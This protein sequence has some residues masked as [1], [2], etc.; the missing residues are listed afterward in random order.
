[1]LQNFLFPVSPGTSVNK[2]KSQAK[3]IRS[4]E[5]EKVYILMVVAGKS[6][7]HLEWL[8]KIEQEMKELGLPVE[9]MIRYGHVPS[10]IVNAARSTRSIICFLKK[11]KNP[12]KKALA[13]S[14]VSDVVRM[15]DEPVLIYKKTFTLR[16]E[17][18][19][20]SIMYA[21]NFKRSTSTCVKYIQHKAFKARRLILLHVGRRAPDPEAEKKR[22]EKIY[23]KLDQLVAECQNGF[24][25][26][27]KH[28]VLGLGADRKILHHARKNEVDLLIIGK[29]DRKDGFRRFT[30]STVEAIYNRAPCS[31]LI[32][33]GQK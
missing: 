25:T 19:L 11:W 24:E 5:P 4:F 22:L 9:H 12:L 6:S 27:E 21:T 33:P 29:V 7:R 18:G 31:V 20:G 23:S 15:C 10:Q 30:G 8:D 26:I 17:H 1:M 2:I 3:F 16:S 28:E 14:V 32:I 13:G